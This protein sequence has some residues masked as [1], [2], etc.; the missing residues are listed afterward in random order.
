MF[1]HKTDNQ[2]DQDLKALG[3]MIAS[4]GWHVLM[5]FLEGDLIASCVGMGSGPTISNDEL[6]FRAG[7]IY[8]A[9]NLIKAPTKIVEMLRA[10]LAIREAAAKAKAATEAATEIKE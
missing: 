8:A 10:E 2:L 6:R 5:E 4:R 1:D 9:N 7:A 3:D